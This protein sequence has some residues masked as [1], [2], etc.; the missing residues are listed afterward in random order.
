MNETTGA[1]RRDRPEGM[2]CRRRKQL[3]DRSQ[4]FRFGVTLSFYAFLMLVFFFGLTLYPPLLT[5]LVGG[6]ELTM[7]AYRTA[8]LQFAGFALQFWWISLLGFFLVGCA[9]VVLSHRIFGPMRRLEEI[10]WM[11]QQSPDLRVDCVLRKGDYFHAFSRLLEDVLNQS[12]EE[13]AAQ[14]STPSAETRPA[15]AGLG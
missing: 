15:P 1:P 11:K 2:G 4:Q 7:K 6:E 10:L 5:L 13:K 9:S 14:A 8:V 12:E 3:V